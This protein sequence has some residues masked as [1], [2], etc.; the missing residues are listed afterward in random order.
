[1][2]RF[3]RGSADV[4]ERLGGGQFGETTSNT[5][6]LPKKAENEFQFPILLY[7]LVLT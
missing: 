4:S 5:M 3:F 7:Q 6:S 2:K 1:M